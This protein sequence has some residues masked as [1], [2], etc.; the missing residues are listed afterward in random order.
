M[1]KR[2]ARTKTIS[3]DD[4]QWTFCPHCKG[5]VYGT[6]KVTFGMNWNYAGGKKASW[7]KL[8]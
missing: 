6:S 7:K 5:K 4:I 2:K 1:K 3:E 8:N